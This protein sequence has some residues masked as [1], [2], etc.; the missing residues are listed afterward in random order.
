MENVLLVAYLLIVL[1][2]IVEP[3]LVGLVPSVGRFGPVTAL[4]NGFTDAA[5]S[6]ADEFFS[7]LPALGFMLLWVGALFAASAAV[8]RRRDLSA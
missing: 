3:L 4:P 6:E 8:L 1:A 7:P 2:L 5:G